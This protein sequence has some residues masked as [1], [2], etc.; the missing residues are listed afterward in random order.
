MSKL[1]Q[2]FE[3]YFGKN[4]ADT[5]AIMRESEIKKTHLVFTKIEISIFILAFLFLR[6][7]I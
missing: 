6:D 4:A 1:V 3:I 7:L 5:P 2:S